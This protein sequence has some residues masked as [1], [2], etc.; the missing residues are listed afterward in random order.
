M[1]YNGSGTFQINTSGQPVVAGTVISATA[2]NALTADLATGLS[3]AITKDGQTTTT[4]RIPF[5]AG[6]SS[7]LTTDSSSVSTGSIITAGGI[8][9]AKAAYIGTTLNV[10]GASTFTGS[11]AVDSVTDSSS[12]TTGSIQTDGGVGIAKALFV[13]TTANIAGVTTVQAGTA[14]LPAITTTGDTNTGIFFPAADT[15]AFSEGGVESARFDASGN[16]GLGVTPSAWASAYKAIQLTEGVAFSEGGGNTYLSNN[17]FNDGTNKYIANGTAAL[18]GQSG[19]QHQW[20]TA[21]SGTAG[22]TISFTTAM[23]L[24]ANGVLALQGASTSADGVGITFPATQSASSD[25]NTLDD[26]EEGNWT[27]V[28]TTG[29][30]SITSY[31]STGRYTKIGRTVICNCFINITNNGTGS[32]SGDVAGL[33][34]APASAGTTA[35]TRDYSAT[36]KRAIW[37]CLATATGGFIIA[38]D[39][40]YPWDTGTTFNMSF[41]YQI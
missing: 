8:G 25:V 5:A 13:G 39:G 29:S 26:Y 37:Q 28:P 22:N 11:I 17:W 38:T 36:G 2:F 32:V 30:G 19:G 7:T 14:S 18:Y 1:S 24:N 4:A 9:A 21:A 3:T 12:T 33:P 15:I 6:I 10:G 40:T 27:P 23:T 41:C 31:T 35:C 20:L 16:M 34:F